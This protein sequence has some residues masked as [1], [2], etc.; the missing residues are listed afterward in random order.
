[1]PGLPAIDQ[2]LHRPILPLSLLVHDSNHDRSGRSESQKGT[3][4]PN[5]CSQAR[6][7]H[8]TVV[9]IVLDEQCCSSCFQHT[10]RCEVRAQAA[11]TPLLAFLNREIPESLGNGL[12][13]HEQ[14]CQLREELYLSPTS[15][16][17]PR[18][19]PGW[20]SQI[21]RSLSDR[22]AG[23]HTRESYQ[24]AT[25]KASSPGRMLHFRC[26]IES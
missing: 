12:T 18:L 10:M 23:I 7:L 24:A 26:W 22:E 16:D 19:A 14:H 15:E 6:W 9:A 1:M 25:T 3:C 13:R 8:V 17:L 2:H 5:V 11:G 4:L 20:R 21:R